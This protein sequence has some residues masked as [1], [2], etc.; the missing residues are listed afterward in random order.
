MKILVVS[1]SHGNT[2]ALLNA[3]F[4]VSPQL[5][6]HLGDYERDCGK[7]RGAFPHLPVRAVRGNGDIRS[8]EPDYDEFVLERRRFFMTHGHLYGVKTGLEALKSAGRL[9]RTD[10]LLFGHTH[11]AY[12]E[13]FGGMLLLN[14]G[15]IGMG[16]KTYAVLSVEHGEISCQ[17]MNLV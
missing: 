4:D 12:R 8:M 10:V 13:D 1:D 15:S 3:V 9:R 6:L 7:L 11:R 5:V 14:P 16:A 2:Q 17:I